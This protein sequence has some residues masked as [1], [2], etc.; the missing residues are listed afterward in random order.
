MEKLTLCIVALLY[1]LNLHAQNLSLQA[2]PVHSPPYTMESN[3]EITGYTTEIVSL[4]LDELGGQQALALYPLK[5]ALNI[6]AKQANVLIYPI[7]RS[8]QLEQQFHWV[9]KISN[10]NTYLFKLKSR[11]DLQTAN[12][13]QAKNLNVGVIRGSDIAVHLSELGFT[14]IFEVSTGWQNI[15]KLQKH[16]IDLIAADEV[17]FTHLID[18]FNRSNSQ[19]LNYQEFA[20]ALDISTQTDY[21]LYIALSKTTPSEVVDRV[22]ETYDSITK[23]GTVIEVVHWWTS[24][25]ELPF[26][27]VYRQAMTDRGLNWLDYTFEG[28]AGSNINQI[29]NPQ[30]NSGHIPQ[31]IRSYMGP[32]VKAWQTDKLL[33]VDNVA[34]TESWHTK[35]AT[36]VD[37]NIKINGSYY[38]VPIN[39]QRVNWMW[40]NPSV[41]KIANANIPNTWSEFLVAAEKIKQTGI[42]PIS[43]GSSPWQ[44]GTLFEVLVLSLGGEA[45]YKE[46]FFQLK[47]QLFVSATMD[48]ILTLM[49]DIRAYSNYQNDEVTWVQATNKIIEGT[50]AVYFMGDWVNGALKFK[51]MPHGPEGY[52]CK[53]VIGT[54][55]KVLLNTDVF[56]LPKTR[57]SDELSQKVMAS[58]LMNEDVQIDFNKAKG[59]VPAR[60]DLSIDDFDPCSQ[61]T[62]QLAKQ[63][64]LLPSFNFGQVQP[65]VVKDLIVEQ[66]SDYFRGKADK[67]TTMQS[68]RNIAHAHKKAQKTNN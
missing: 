6:A 27:N 8:P 1:S 33:N 42:T 2:T 11:T 37:E 7:R 54:E 41:F 15:G 60:L 64:K 67:K 29:L 52:L 22:I 35:L 65:E 44:H 19:K 62:F 31:A 23:S 48:K 45:F 32:G 24:D 30:I 56:V 18:Q 26:I 38:A 49:A 51:G 50:A 9:G 47:P 58:M 16:R 46:L 13:A 53:P 66:V 4:M 5:R 34:K 17:T 21:D 68:L 14:N 36:V 55:D 63:N 28:G 20:K 57:I 59:S 3:G 10:Q 25:F 43:I 12:L 39:M 61:S 40:L